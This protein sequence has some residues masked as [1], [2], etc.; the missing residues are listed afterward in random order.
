MTYTNAVLT[1]CCHDV[2]TNV[3]ML[4]VMLNMHC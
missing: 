4:V 3:T 2:A 1:H